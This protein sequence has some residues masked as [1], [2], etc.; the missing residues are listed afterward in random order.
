[1]SVIE[2]LA[3]PSSAR[4]ETTGGAPPPAPGG[5][6]PTRHAW[7]PLDRVRVGVAL[8]GLGCVATAEGLLPGAG[9]E[10]LSTAGVAALAVAAVLLLARRP[11]RTRASGPPGSPGSDDEV[12]HSVLPAP[13]AGASISASRRKWRWT[14]VG[15]TLA[16]GL[17]VQ[18]WFRAGTAIAGGD[19]GPPLGTAWITR[20]FAPIAWSGADLGGPNQSQLELPWAAVV[21]FTHLAGGSGALAQRIWLTALLAAVPLAAAALTRAL[22][23]SPLAG[24]AAALLYAFSPYLVSIGGV[25][26]VYLVATVLLAALPALVVAAGR[27]TVPT[28]AASLGLLLAAPL[29]GYAYANPPL[30][31]MIAG[32]LVLSPGLA[33]ARYGRRAGIRSTWA[34]LIGGLLLVGGS[35]YW[36]I[37]AKTGLAQVA[38]SSLSSLAA[39]GWSESRATLANALWLNTSWTWRYTYYVPYAPDFARLP[40]VLLRPLLPLVA[41]GALALRPLHRD[42]PGVTRV[43]ALVALATLGIMTFSTGTRSPG[44]VL[45]DPLYSLPYG[46]LL[47]EPGRFL[48]AAA[49]GVALLG[50][51]LVEQLCSLPMR[52][53]PRLLRRGTGTQQTHTLGLLGLGAVVLVALTSFPLW[54]GRVVPGPRPPFPSSHVKIPTSWNA[55]ATYLNAPGAPSGHLLALPPESSI[56]IPFSW[57]YG[58]NGFV[59]QLLRRPVVDPSGQGYDVVSSELSSASQLEGEALVARDWTEARRL[60]GA[61]DTPLV[62]VEGDVETP[63][64][65]HSIISPALLAAR[66]RADPLMRPLRRFGPL[67]LFTVRA[68][69]LPPSDFATVD[70]ATPDLRALALLPWSTALV[71]SQPI[72]G[73][74]ALFQLPPVATWGLGSTHL[75]T[76]LAELP[77]RHYVPAVLG[78]SPT[79]RIPTG[80][81]RWQTS[82]AAGRAPRLTLSLPVGPSLIGD[83]DFASGAWGPVGNCNDAHPVVAPQFVS[84]SVLPLAG[85]G[86]SPALRLEADTDG[87]CEAQGL[88]WHGGSVLLRLSV[89]SITGAP[90]EVCLWEQPE[91]RCAAAPP[92][93]QATGWE[94]YRAVLTPPPGTQSLSLYLYAYSTAQGQTTVSEFA[95]I[96]VR[97]LQA[98][99]Q[100]DVLAIPGHA[101]AQLAL[102]T[103]STGFGPGWG[104]HGGG[105]HVEVDGLRN[106]WILAGPQTPGVVATAYG[107]ALGEWRRELLLGGICLAVALSLAALRRLRVRSAD[108]A[109]APSR[110]AP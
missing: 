19:I 49:L 16:Q 106:A 26:D 11:I 58:T 46:W 87:A 99:P 71:T 23:L 101:G 83:G 29:L 4:T 96:I 38:T 98:A 89:R 107:P 86:R 90:A 85:P 79:G 28:W 45:F 65:G 33:W 95:N 93:P 81:L 9:Q 31:G 14:L 17:L 80:D 59:A 82:D 2:E 92:L 62:L 20:L 6:P 103:G 105:R 53:L 60:L 25:S 52:H 56:Y 97:S 66:L 100:V 109:D 21:W 12:S 64:P 67:Q 108:L 51:L 88:S 44:N 54:S 61:M 68:A 7:P 102:L 77:G 43:T 15:V 63:F 91:D 78:L 13:V 70:T 35:A 75:S 30:V 18:T 72:P 55:M 3:A 27:G 1:M 41:F 5:R 94:R 42:R 84:G 37:P 47:R 74:L 24:V 36:A 10:I 73:H 76:T 69:L 110:E 32:V 50:A 22:G 57:Y 39:W 104:Y 48:M 40:L 8:V 34:L